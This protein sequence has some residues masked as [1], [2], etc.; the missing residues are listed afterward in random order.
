MAEGEQAEE[1][2][3]DLLSEA[4]YREETDASEDEEPSDNTEKKKKV[5]RK[6]VYPALGEQVRLSANTIKMKNMEDG[7]VKVFHGL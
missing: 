1:E 2:I 4:A 5:K 7:F 3:D 6:E